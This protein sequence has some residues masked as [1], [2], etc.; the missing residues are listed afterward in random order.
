M[1]SVKRKTSV[2]AENRSLVS[3]SSSVHKIYSKV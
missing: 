1:D 3:R 2:L